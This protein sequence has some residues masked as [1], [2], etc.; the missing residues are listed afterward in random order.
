M[1]KDMVFATEVTLLQDNSYVKNTNDMTVLNRYAKGPSI[2][3]VISRGEGGVKNC[4][5]YLVKND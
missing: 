2:N 1:L 3:Y 5:F 4:Q